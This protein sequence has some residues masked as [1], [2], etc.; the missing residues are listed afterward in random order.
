MIYTRI[1]IINNKYFSILNKQI[2]RRSIRKSARSRISS[3]GVLEIYEGSNRR[4]SVV[5]IQGEYQR[6]HTSRSSANSDIRSIKLRNSLNKNDSELKLTR[7]LT[8][9]TAAFLVSWCPFTIYRLTVEPDYKDRN[10]VLFDT[11]YWLALSNSLINPFI[12][13]FSTPGFLDLL[14]I[15]FMKNNRNALNSRL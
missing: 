9:I 1:R 10:I 13:A 3:S 8:I 12:Y 15:T 2:G 11:L 7:T 6:Q 4:C 14:K 5:T